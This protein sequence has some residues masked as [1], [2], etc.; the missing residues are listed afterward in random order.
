MCYRYPNLRI[1]TGAVRTASRFHRTSILLI[2]CHY[3]AGAAMM[4]IVPSMQPTIKLAR[5]AG[6]EHRG[7]WVWCRGNRHTVG[8]TMRRTNRHSSERC[9]QTLNLG[10]IGAVV[11]RD[12]DSAGFRRQADFWPTRAPSST[13]TV[14]LRWWLRRLLFRLPFAFVVLFFLFDRRCC[15]GHGPGKWGSW[16]PSDQVIPNLFQVRKQ[17]VD[18]LL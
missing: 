6:G 4:R 8:K 16:V 9:I 7:R 13:L 11:R 10:D 14:V 18:A 5:R 12:R 3:L 2:G 17:R 1:A 15:S